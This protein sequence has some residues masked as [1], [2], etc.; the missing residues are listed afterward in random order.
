VGT[1]TVTCSATNTLGT[2]T[3]TFT[4]T[5]AARPVLTLPEDAVD[6]PTGSSA[7]LD[8]GS[9]PSGS[10]YVV[11]WGDGRATRDTVAGEP[12]P[13]HGYRGLGVYT[14]TV[15]AYDGQGVASA[16]ATVTV[17]VSGTQL[18]KHLRSTVGGTSCVAA[19]W[20]QPPARDLLVAGTAGDDVIVL[21]AVP[22]GV[23][24]DVGGTRTV[25]ELTAAVLVVGLGGNDTV[26]ID[27]ALTVPVTVD[28]DGAAR[29]PLGPLC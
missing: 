20:W 15:V 11:D 2:G 28:Q 23:Q 6:V 8:L 7:R 26:T 12:E 16:P 19:P 5:V 13:G 10:R 18:V 27:P 3:A 25:Y 4:V 21:T 9:L 22:G 29:T 24:V 17:T 14:V 1:T